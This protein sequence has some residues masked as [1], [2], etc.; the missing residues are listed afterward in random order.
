M[1]LEGDYN[2]ELKFEDAVH[3]HQLNDGVEYKCLIKKLA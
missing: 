3:E 2:W 1:H